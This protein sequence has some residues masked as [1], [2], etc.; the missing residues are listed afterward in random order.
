MSMSYREE[1]VEKTD[2]LHIRSFG[3]WSYEGGEAS[4]RK[5]AACVT[6]GKFDKV[7]I[8]DRELE[9]TFST[10]SEFELAGLV[11]DMLLGENCRIAMV[12]RPERHEVNG[13]FENVCVNRGL[14]MK[15]FHTEEAALEWLDVLP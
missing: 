3:E 9:A 6:K 4:W 8:D 5:V 2:F 7:L 11:V 14:Q 12:D 10:I 15:F 1:I 13:F